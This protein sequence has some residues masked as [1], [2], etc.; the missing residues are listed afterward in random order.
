MR[1]RDEAMT[2]HE[3]DTRTL[4]ALELESLKVDLHRLVRYM[5]ELRERAKNRAVGDRVAG[6]E[7]WVLGSAQGI[8]HRMNRA[9]NESREY[10]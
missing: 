10:R 5:D 8:A 9:F 1:K 3:Q 6:D 4:S 2:T 7:G